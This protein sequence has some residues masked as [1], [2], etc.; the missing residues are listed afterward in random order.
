MKKIF[1]LNL[2]IAFVL[3]FFLAGCSQDKNDDQQMEDI[4][5]T[6]FWTFY[7]DNNQYMEEFSFLNDGTCKYYESYEPDDDNNEE[8]YSDFGEGTYTVEG[9]QLTLYLRFNDEVEIWRY[10]I[11]SLKSKK[12][13]ELMDEYG[14]VYE[15]SYF[16][17]L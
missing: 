9:D 1:N 7:A 4:N 13:L 3:G 17:G 12:K 11:K 15:Y 8:P 2:F 6:G 10:T 14:D 16:D 5:I